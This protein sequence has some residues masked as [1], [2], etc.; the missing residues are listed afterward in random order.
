MSLAWL[1]E[2]VKKRRVFEKVFIVAINQNHM[3]FLIVHFKT[4]QQIANLT[5]EVLWVAFSIQPGSLSLVKYLVFHSL[6]L[7]NEKF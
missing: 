5:L 3:C 4:I 1:I 6:T 7:I 2:I